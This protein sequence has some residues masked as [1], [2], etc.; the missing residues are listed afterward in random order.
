MNRVINPRLAASLVGTALGLPTHP[1]D[2]LIT[3]DVGR[4]LVP[5]GTASVTSHGGE[6]FRH[7]PDRTAKPGHYVVGL[8]RPVCGS[9]RLLPLKGVVP[10]YLAAHA[11]LEPAFDASKAPVLP[12]DERAIGR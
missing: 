7:V 8:V 4:R 10:L 1:H 5:C 2:R 6:A 3:F 9:A 11:G 12:L